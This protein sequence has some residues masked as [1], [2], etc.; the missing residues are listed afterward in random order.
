MYK[1][2]TWTQNGYHRGQELYSRQ[3]IATLL[4]HTK[5]PS[6]CYA[7][8]QD[9]DQQGN[10]L[11]SL[12][13]FDIDCPSLYDAHE[14]MLEIC[15]ELETDFGLE[16]MVW[17]S[18]SKGFHIIVPKYI[19]HYRCHEIVR[20]LA[21]P[22]VKRYDIDTSVYRERSMWRCNNTW[23]SKGEKFKIR[24]PKDT[25][26]QEILA[27]ANCPQFISSVKTPEVRTI[28][29]EMLERWVKHLPDR[30]AKAVAS[31]NDG[32]DMMPCL[33]KLWNMEAPPSGYAHQL[34]HV[35]SRWCFKSGLTRQDAVSLFDEHVFW[36]KQNPRDYEKVI[37][38]VYRTG[39]AH[40]GC[41]TGRDAE[42]LQ[43]HCQ[44][45]CHFR[46]DFNLGRF[47]NGKDSTALAQ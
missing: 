32:E 30:S 8:V 2:F 14:Q 29:P 25:P 23:N 3:Q 9:Y 34:C 37:D 42:I 17:F 11:G 18:G 46:D 28:L 13:Y 43:P 24:I 31:S 5:K 22:Y 26:L 6:E 35:V 21:Q 1:Y 33:K 20:M 12:V 39:R 41:K 47:I 27:L 16:P 44:L 4:A 40:I 45:V 15:D 38:S 7:T 10:T 19:N 36:K